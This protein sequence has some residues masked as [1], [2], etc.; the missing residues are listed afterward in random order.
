METILIGFVNG[1]AQNGNTYTK[2]SVLR[3]VT[4]REQKYGR[5]GKVCDEYYLPSDMAGSVKASDLGKSIKLHFEV[6]GQRANLI[7]FDIGK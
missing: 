5:F 4:E 3:N 1:K 2:I 6:V 7:G